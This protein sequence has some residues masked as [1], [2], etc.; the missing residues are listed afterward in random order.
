M[1]TI[2]LLLSL[3][4]KF[5]ETNFS[6]NACYRMLAQ[7]NTLHFVQKRGKVGEDRM[8]KHICVRLLCLRIF[9]SISFAKYKCTS[10][11]VLFVWICFRIT[12]RWWWSCNLSVRC[13]KENLSMVC[14]C[15]ETLRFRLSVNKWRIER[16]Y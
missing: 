7:S 2:T 13:E 16:I 6:P 3:R 1:L 12:K 8:M 15:A 9:L 4:S 5:N 11:S 10:N 14:F